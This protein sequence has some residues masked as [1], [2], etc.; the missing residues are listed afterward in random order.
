MTNVMIDLE[1]MGKSNRAPITQIGAVVMDFER[2]ELGDTFHIHVNLEN[3]VRWGGVM[4]ASTVIWWLQQSPEARREFE[5]GVHQ[6]SLIEALCAFAK[7]LP[8]EPNVWGN[9]SR[10][11]NEILDH[12]YRSCGLITPWGHRQDRCYR[13]IKALHPEVRYTPPAIKHHA[14]ED[15]VAQAKHLLAILRPVGAHPSLGASYG[16]K[17]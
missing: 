11:D 2:G 15:A 9:G 10:F 6:K 5:P 17:D 16:K 7:W 4:D 8:P 14:L 12:A 1:T 13:T 3:S